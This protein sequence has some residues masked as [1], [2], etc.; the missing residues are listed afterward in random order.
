[1]P[2]RT[3]TR[4]KEPI[5]KGN[6]GSGRP[7][8]AQGGTMAQQA[9]NYSNNNNAAAGPSGAYDYMAGP[10][11]GPGTNQPSQS[12]NP[13]WWEKAQQRLKK[14]QPTGVAGQALAG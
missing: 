13:T 6:Q 12:A 9:I 14:R 5:K 2:G 4:T 3:R 7:W 8:W 10:G 11:Y 1:M